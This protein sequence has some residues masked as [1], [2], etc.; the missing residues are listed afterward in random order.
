MNPELTSSQS[1]AAAEI[2]VTGATGR[3]GAAVCAQ[4]AA[5]GYQVRRFSSRAG[6]SPQAIAI[7]VTR[8]ESLVGSFDGCELLIHCAGTFQAADAELWAVNTLGTSHVVAEAMAAQ[9]RYLLLVSS[10]SVSG[11]GARTDP[12]IRS[13]AL[14]E[15][16][17]ASSALPRAGI[18]RAGWVLGRQ[19]QEAHAKLW[20]PSTRQVVLRDAR[21]PIIALPD[22]AALISVAVRL[23]ISGVIEG[24]TASP[25]QEELVEFA[26]GIAG[27]RRRIIRTTD[28]RL[29]QRLAGMR[30]GSLGVYRDTYFTSSAP[31][32]SGGAVAARD[33]LPAALD[34]RQAV[35]DLY[36][37]LS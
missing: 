28:P 30:G 6:G 12:Y 19:D 22:L 10:S 18:V 1:S 26:E 15:Q 4:L 29:L 17:V 37:S 5:S 20:P 25:T 33:L 7:D 23:E 21:V 9:V 3:I 13:K 34:W 36:A 14:A 32:A 16:A 11:G 35:S 8:P 2:A 24:F 27:R 31:P